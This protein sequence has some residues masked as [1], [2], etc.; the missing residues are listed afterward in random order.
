MEATEALGD[1]NRSF[2]KNQYFP[3]K[4]Q[5]PNLPVLIREAE[6]VVPCAYARFGA[7]KEV[8]VTLDGLTEEQ[9]GQRIQEVIN[10]QS[11]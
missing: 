1:G 4:Q 3:L 2:I 10:T 7:G 9:V 8:K 11:L 6:G 5:W